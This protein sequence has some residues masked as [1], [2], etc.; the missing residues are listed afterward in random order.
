MALSFLRPVP[1][2]LNL[3]RAHGIAA[4]LGL[5][6]GQGFLWSAVMVS[7][8]ALGASIWLSKEFSAPVV[9]M[10]SWGAAYTISVSFWVLTPLD[11]WDVFFGA[12]GIIALGGVGYGLAGFALR[13]QFSWLAF[14]LAAGAAE[15]CFTLAGYSLAPIGLWVVETPVG[16]IIKLGS[17]YFASCGTCFAAWIISRSIGHP[18]M[19]TAAASFMGLLLFPGPQLPPAPLNIVGISVNPDPVEKWS[20]SG[21]H[22]VLERLKSE[23]AKVEGA[24]LIVWPE[25]AVTT[26]FDLGDALRQ[27]GDWSSPLLFGMSR[28]A[29]KG[30]PELLNSAVLV[31]GDRVSLTNKRILAPIY[32]AGRKG[33]LAGDRSVLWLERNDK[34]I[35]VL[36]CYEAVFMLSRAETVNADM[37]V[38]LAAESG[39]S[40]R[41]SQRVMEANM[42]ARSAESGMPVVRVSDVR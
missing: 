41:M 3:L 18:G 11:G 4:G 26:T 2:N 1:F 25:N 20:V 8:F 14:P 33:L 15:Y 34:K 27:V 22:A 35:I 36:I 6:A 29:R 32:E 38:V 42:K 28:Y 9:I 24:D 17:V 13:S 37:V 23:T 40:K 16:H 10:S 19:R 39:F 31:E 5:V 30:S 7:V 21:G 12:T